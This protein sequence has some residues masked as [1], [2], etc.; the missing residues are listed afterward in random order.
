MKGVHEYR[1]RLRLP[2]LAFPA[3]ED[4]EEDWAPPSYEGELVGVACAPT[5]WTS[6]WGARLGPVGVRPVVA[7]RHI[8]L[9][10]VARYVNF[11][12]SPPATHSGE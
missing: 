10:A 5:G 1:A 4:L 12:E 6:C 2:E 7:E 3:D 8:G 11:R 9:A